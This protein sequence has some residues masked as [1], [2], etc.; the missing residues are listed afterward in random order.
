MSGLRY[1]GGEGVAL[2]WTWEFGCD[3]ERGKAMKIIKPQWIENYPERDDEFWKQFSDPARAYS[4]YYE[5][6]MAY[7]T[8]LMTCVESDYQKH[9]WES[10]Q[11]NRRGEKL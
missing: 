10:S 8:G 1:R 4:N 11:V 5:L 6:F 3:I 2:A 7:S 9:A